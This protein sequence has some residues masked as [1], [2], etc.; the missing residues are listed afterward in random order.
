MEEAAGSRYERDVY[1]DA[2]ILTL[3]AISGTLLV[4]NDFAP[5]LHPIIEE[6]MG[7]LLFMM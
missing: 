1:R 6:H 2:I 4:R 5:S 3:P 7:S